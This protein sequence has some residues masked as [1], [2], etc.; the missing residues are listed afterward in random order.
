M[1]T[2]V[3]LEVYYTK[4]GRQEIRRDTAAEPEQKTIEAKPEQR[5]LKAFETEGTEAT[6]T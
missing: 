5:V 2:I 6:A 1:R 4:T 3:P